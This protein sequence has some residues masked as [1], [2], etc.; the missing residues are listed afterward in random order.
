MVKLTYD[1]TLYDLEYC[2]VDILRQIWNFNTHSDKLN[3][4]DRIVREQWCINF[5]RKNGRSIL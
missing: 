4:I 3:Y 2:L 1:P 5:A